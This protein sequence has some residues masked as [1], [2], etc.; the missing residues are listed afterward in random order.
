MRFYLLLL[1][2]VLSLAPVQVMGAGTTTERR[3]NK[4]H[5]PRLAALHGAAIGRAR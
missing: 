4:T 5:Q 1:F 2:V 3:A